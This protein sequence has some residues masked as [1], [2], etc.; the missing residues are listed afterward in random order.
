M[1]EQK[2][3]ASRKMKID[4]INYSKRQKGKKRATHLH[5][6]L[7][8]KSNIQKSNNPYSGS[9]KHL[10]PSTQFWGA[11]SPLSGPVAPEDLMHQ[12]IVLAVS[13]RYQLLDPPSN[14]PYGFLALRYL[15]IRV[16]DGLTLFIYYNV[17]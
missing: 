5:E 4:S 16:S 10:L 6:Q 11:T 8:L 13:I 12:Q 14:P 15:Q 7:S 17:N 1:Q 2:H 9:I 3:T